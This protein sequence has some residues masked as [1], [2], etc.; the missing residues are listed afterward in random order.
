ME[1]QVSAGI[2]GTGSFLPDQV[3]SNN[4][5]EKLV[6]TRNEWICARTGIQERRIAQED[7]SAS[8]L[9][10]EA[11]RRA[12]KKSCLSADRIDLIIVAT[13]T[14]DMFFPSTACIVQDRIGAVNAA[15]FDISAACTGFIY[16]LSIAKQ[17]IKTKTYRYILVIGVEVMSKIVDWS[18]RNTCI[19]FGDGAGAA[20]LG[21]VDPQR[22]IR[23]SQLKS[24]GSGGDLLKL[25]AGGSKIPCSQHSLD[26]GLHFLKMSGKDIF[27]FAVK[28]MEE[29]TRDAL[30]SCGLEVSDIDLLIPHQAN[31]RIISSGAKRLKLPLEKVWVNIHRYGNISAASIPVALDEALSS[32][33]I[34]EG[35][36][37]VLVGF[38]GGLTWGVNII[39]WQ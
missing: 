19:L 15:A 24:D 12:L 23:F 26:N 25:P 3:L 34:K 1:Q 28:V 39:R 4:D 30:K 29:S 14:P 20:V 37:V 31:L 8:D 2:I 5:L 10:V 33:K 27:K 22:G 7:V 32:G 17:F 11:A 36:L 6:D 16:G 13:I 38:G 18:D 21:P 35:S 9:A